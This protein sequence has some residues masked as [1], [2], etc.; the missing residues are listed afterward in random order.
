MLSFHA[1]VPAYLFL[2]LHLN[3]ELCLDA[4][5]SFALVLIPGAAQRVHFVDE[6]DGGFVLASQVKQVLH[7]PE[8]HQERWGKRHL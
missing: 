4:T 5:G 1:V 2:T 3:Q 8:G 7:Q 6:D